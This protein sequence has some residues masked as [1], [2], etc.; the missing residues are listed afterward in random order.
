MPLL[1]FRLIYGKR[2]A[3]SLFQAA[4]LLGAAVIH[5]SKR[6]VVERLAPPRWVRSNV[7]GHESSTDPP[8]RSRSRRG[9]ISE[10]EHLT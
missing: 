2:D 10:I 5:F 6:A 1:D 4:F 8:V 9:K 3:V 7:A